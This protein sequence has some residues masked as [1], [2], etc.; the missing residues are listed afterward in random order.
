MKI[1]SANNTN[2]LSKGRCERIT[3]CR[4]REEARRT[5]DE[6]GPQEYSLERDTIPSRSKASLDTLPDAAEDNSRPREDL[7][8]RLSFFRADVLILHQHGPSLLL[9]QSWLRGANQARF[10]APIQ[11]S[12]MRRHSQTH[13]I[14]LDAWLRR[15]WRLHDERL[16]P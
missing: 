13:A 1:K 16:L 11:S 12:R 4:R 3:Q 5:Q 9:R 7:A 6:G 15:R 2:C 10:Y 8:H 14:L